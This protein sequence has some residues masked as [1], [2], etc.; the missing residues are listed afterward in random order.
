MIEC[1]ECQ[2]IS[3]KLDFC[4]F[5][6][7]SQW[8]EAHGLKLGA[9]CIRLCSA[10]VSSNTSA[11]FPSIANFCYALFFF[12]TQASPMSVLPS[13]EF[14]NGDDSM[15]WSK[16]DSANSKFPSISLSLSHTYNSVFKL[17]L[18]PHVSLHYFC[19]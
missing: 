14:W 8:F 17:V 9:F 19:F 1:N 13:S 2:G 18:F 10:V 5:K 4:F 11:W 6:L 12:V 15:C 3:P 16:D 7:S